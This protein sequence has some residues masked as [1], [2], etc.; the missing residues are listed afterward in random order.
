M[1]E[2]SFGRL[3]RTN[4]TVEWLDALFSTESMK[5]QWRDTAYLLNTFFF[6]VAPFIIGPPPCVLPNLL[7]IAPQLACPDLLRYP[8]Q[9]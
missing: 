6:I 5:Q 8:L 1:T 9:H 7:V 4:P 2:P 3:K